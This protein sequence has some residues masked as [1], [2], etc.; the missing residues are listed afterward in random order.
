MSVS[1]VFRINIQARFFNFCTIWIHFSLTTISQWY[2]LKVKR[3]IAQFQWQNLVHNFLYSYISFSYRFYEK[4]LYN[5]TAWSIICS[6]S[7]KIFKSITCSRWHFFSFAGYF[8]KYSTY[9][10]W[11]NCISHFARQSSKC[12]LWCLLTLGS[13]ISAFFFLLFQQIP[14]PLSKLF[15]WI[16]PIYY[17]HFKEVW[18]PTILFSIILFF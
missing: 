17:F 6:I 11:S 15:P 12:T 4:L 13:A 2:Y 18:K 16:N 14:S 1:N 7:Y 10:W 9:A 8:V 5:E 3:R